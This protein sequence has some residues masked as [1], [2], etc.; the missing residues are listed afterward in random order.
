MAIGDQVCNTRRCPFRD[1]IWRSPF[2]LGFLLVLSGTCVAPVQATVQEASA[3]APAASSTPGDAPVIDQLEVGMAGRYRSGRW[4]RLA[5]QIKAGSRPFH[6]SVEVICRDGDGV[7]TRYQWQNEP[8][9]EIAAG[10]TTRVTRMVKMGRR[11]GSL[12]IELR[13]GDRRIAVR[14]YGR[15]ELPEPF[16]AEREL[17]VTFGPSSGAAELTERKSAGGQTPV[18]QP[19]S[20]A[21]QWPDS[22]LGWDA[23]DMVVVTT[24]DLELIRSVSP[25]QV[26]ALREW[27]ERGGRLILSLGKNGRELAGANSPWSAFVPGTFVDVGSLTSLSELE[28]YTGSAEQLDLGSA[29][30]NGLPITVVRDVR[31]QV[32]LAHQQGSEQRPLLIR[33]VPGFGELVFSAMDLDLPPISTWEGRSK[34]ISRLLY[35]G[36]HQAPQRTS[37]STG[38]SHGARFGYHDMVGQLWSGMDQFPGISLVAFATVTTLVVV[39]VLLIG[40]VD[41]FLMRDVIRKMTWTWFTFPLVTLLFVGLAWWMGPQGRGTKVLLN[42]VDLVDVDARSGIARGLTWA[43]V[44][45]PKAGAFQISSRLTEESGRLFSVTGHVL[46]WHGLPGTGLGGLNTAAAAPPAMDEYQ[47]DF[48]AATGDTSTRGAANQLRH[49]PVNVAATKSL[50]GTWWGTFQ[51]QAPSELRAD[52]DGLLTGEVRNPLPVELDDCVVY[53]DK[54]AYRLDAKGGLLKSGESTRMERERALN[55]QWRLT[56]RRVIENAKDLSTP[57]D[58]HTLEVPKILEMMM[59]HSAA[60]GETYTQLVNRFQSYVDLSS[61]LTTDVAI[62]IGRAPR[63]AVSLTLEGQDFPATQQWTYYRLVFPVQSWHSPSGGASAE[64]RD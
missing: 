46:A 29:A 58:Q 14:E 23:V 28:T 62:L 31:G 33:A 25:A 7:S 41:Y 22:W 51:P 39:Y 54:W 34:V 26:S 1:W 61:H 35:S 57:W 9:L 20:S 30:S 55:L 47:L 21:A 37:I 60:G 8:V 44:Y 49:V 36:S 18:V 59:F 27:M 53:F 50:L 45:S 40:P 63:S 42:Q 15:Q 2:L 19:L 48:G 43:H 38:S 10:Q 56:G 32:E 13:E 4:T 5:F 64:S 52:A 16:D 3:D 12:R 6:G 11:D 17:I 24:S